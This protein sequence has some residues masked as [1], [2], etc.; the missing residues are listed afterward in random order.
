MVVEQREGGF[1]FQIRFKDADINTGEMM[2][3]HCRKWF[4]SSWSTETEVVRTVYK[5]IFAAEEHE[6][7]EKFK[8]KNASI[9]NPHTPVGVLVNRLHGVTMD[10]RPPPIHTQIK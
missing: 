4:I 9:Y 8:Y 2:W 3:Q 5:A 1:L 7:C 10:E 6:I